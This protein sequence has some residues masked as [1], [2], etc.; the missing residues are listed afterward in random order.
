MQMKWLY[1]IELLYIYLCSFFPYSLL[2]YMKWYVG[3]SLIKDKNKL[4]NKQFYLEY[5]FDCL[6]MFME[7][8]SQLYSKE[9]KYLYNDT[10]DKKLALNTML[11]YIQCETYARI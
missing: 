5:G 3:P 1:C 8:D 6:T 11:Q 2:K 7:Y 9:M 10:K 4:R